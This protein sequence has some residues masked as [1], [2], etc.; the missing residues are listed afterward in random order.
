MSSRS[1]WASGK[2]PV[3]VWYKDTSQRLELQELTDETSGLAVTTATVTANLYDGDGDPIGGISNP[4]S[5]SHVASGTYRYVLPDD[6]DIEAGQRV[7][8]QWLADDGAGRK[9]KW[10]RRA[11]V[12][13]A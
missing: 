2:P 6:A 11:E 7:E 12:Q 9:A 1:R 13:Y 5:L 8:I 10:V 4:V 3:V